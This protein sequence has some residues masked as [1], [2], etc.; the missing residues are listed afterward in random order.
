MSP[1]EGDVTAALRAADP[2]V[3]ARVEDERTICDL[4]AVDPAD[5]DALA[6]ALRAA[7]KP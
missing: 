5:D 3:I 6:S 4:R 7:T 2:P 1:Y